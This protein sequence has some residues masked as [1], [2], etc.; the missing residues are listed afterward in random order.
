MSIDPSKAVTAEGVVSAVSARSA[1]YLKGLLFKPRPLVILHN[2]TT[3]QTV[4]LKLK[5][6]LLRHSLLI[7]DVHG[8]RSLR[9]SASA[10][11]LI[12]LALNV[13]RKFAAKGFIEI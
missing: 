13:T 6:G 11:V 4:V 8:E 2:M 10:L 12:T 1:E 9:R 7:K 5:R 3:D